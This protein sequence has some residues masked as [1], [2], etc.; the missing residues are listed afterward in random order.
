[1]ETKILD[2]N[3]HKMSSQGCFRLEVPE[4][5]NM[6]RLMTDYWVEHGRGNDVAIYYRD[7]QVTY[8]DLKKLTDSFARALYGLGMRKGDRFLIRTPNCPQY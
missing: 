1:M 4:K 5:L 3:Y 2:Y 6:A 8:Q 7:E